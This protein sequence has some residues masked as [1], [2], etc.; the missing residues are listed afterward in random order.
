M[1]I[2]DNLML[3]THNKLD[4]ANVKTSTSYIVR[5]C[6]DVYRSCLDLS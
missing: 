3:I 5:Y 6:I 1:H 2:L 4:L